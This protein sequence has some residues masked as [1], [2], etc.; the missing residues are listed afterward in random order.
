[1]SFRFSRD[2]A[3]CFPP[4]LFRPLSLSPFIPT[5]SLSVSLR[6]FWRRDGERTAVPNEDQRSRLGNV[7]V[8]S[9][10]VAYTSLPPARIARMLSR[11]IIA[12]RHRQSRS[13]DCALRQRRRYV[14][15]SSRATIVSLC[16]CPRELGARDSPR[17]AETEIENNDASSSRDGRRETL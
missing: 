6:S 14:C 4:S 15:R 11:V 12:S 9:D 13:H 8:P 3:R 2:L 1:M 7:R 10:F 16:G 5:M 17:R